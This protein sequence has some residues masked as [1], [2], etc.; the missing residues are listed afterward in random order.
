MMKCQV[1][2]ILAASLLL[3]ALSASVIFAQQGPAAPTP[4]QLFDRACV[5][6]HGNAAVPRAADPSVLRRMT[7]EQV[8]ESLTTG[9]M[10]AQAQEQ[11]LDDAARR[12]I[13]EYLGDRKLGAGPVGDAKL[14]PN[15]C[16]AGRAM[17]STATTSAWNGWGADHANTRFQPAQS[18]GLSAALLPRLRLK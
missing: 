8:Y 18:A 5:T 11:R 14:M 13:A 2:Y 10:S 17:S 3:C 16:E 4:R 7:P 6:C 1:E 9:V 12:A 15:R